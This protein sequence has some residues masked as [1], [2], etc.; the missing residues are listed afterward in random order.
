MA[1]SEVYLYQNNKLVTPVVYAESVKD[2]DG[3]QKFSKYYNKTD[4]DDKLLTIE[5]E[6]KASVEE[7]MYEELEESISAKME[8]SIDAKLSDNLTQSKNYTDSMLP[9]KASVTLTSGGWSNKVQQVTVSGMTTGCAAIVTPAPDSMDAYVE[10]GVKAT[11]QLDGSLIFT[12]EFA[13]T[14]SLT[15]NIVMIQ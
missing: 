5:N 10:A 13:P 12:C 1:V 3:T 6:I 9:K 4:I 11:T 15:V 7:S 8:G 14:V 2:S